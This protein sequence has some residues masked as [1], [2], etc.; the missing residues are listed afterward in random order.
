MASKARTGNQ[1]NVQ[2][3]DTASRSDTSGFGDGLEMFSEETQR[4]EDVTFKDMLK[5]REAFLKE[6]LKV[7]EDLRKS[8]V[9][10]YKD[11]MNEMRQ[12]FHSFLDIAEKKLNTVIEPQ[13]TSTPAEKDDEKYRL[14]DPLQ[15]RDQHAE[16]EEHQFHGSFLQETPENSAVR[17]KKKNESTEERER[18][19]DAELRI[20]EERENNGPQPG[21]QGGHS[22]TGG[23][24][25]RGDSTRTWRVWH[26]LE[27]FYDG[28]SRRT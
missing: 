25:R 18:P 24:G 9:A 20:I 28:Q 6:Q 26:V 7:S 10:G 21:G 8:Q 17:P 14:P 15:K 22:Q 4:E 1:G 27:K 11:M 23:Q 12:H 16:R 13:F 19:F 5:D 3:D 2:T